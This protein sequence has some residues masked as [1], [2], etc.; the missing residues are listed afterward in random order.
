MFR[1]QNRTLMAVAVAMLL[2]ALGMGGCYLL[3]QEEAALEPPVLAPESVEVS[4]VKVTRGALEQW[5]QAS[6]KIASAVQENVYFQ[7]KGGNVAKV[8]VSSGDTVQKGDVLVEMQTS[9]LEFAKEE[10]EIRYN[11]ARLAYNQGGGQDQKYNLQLAKLALDRATEALEQAVLVSPIDG[12]VMY[13]AAIKPG[14]WVEAYNEIVR[15]ADPTQLRVEISGDEAKA[16][17]TGMQVEV[18]INGQ[19]LTGTVV[20]T[21]ND[22]PERLADSLASDKALIEVEGMPEGVALGSSVIV[23]GVTDSRQDTLIL[24]ASAVKNFMGRTYVQVMRDGV[25]TDVDVKTGLTTTTQVEILE[26]LQ[27]GDEVIQ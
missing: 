18:N 14:D 8:S 3:P 10:A 20:Q 26:G 1:K 6:G 12:V 21:P 9:D 17:S 24:P 19:N 4:T 16:F 5:V 22:Q 23:R 27:E 2:A 7:P 25:K 13:V 15:I 11:Q